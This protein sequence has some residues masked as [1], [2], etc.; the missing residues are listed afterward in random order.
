MHIIGNMNCLWQE[1]DCEMAAPDGWR[2]VICLRCGRKLKPT[3]HDNA[4]IVAECRAFPFWWE[5][6]H[7]AAIFLAAAGLTKGRWNWLRWKL[8][9]TTP[10]GCEQKQEAMNTWGAKLAAWLAK[11]R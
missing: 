6:G 2:C 5:L 1:V 9:L 8:G 3:P 7:W 4:R 10:C 11:R